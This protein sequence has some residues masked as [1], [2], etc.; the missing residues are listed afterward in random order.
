MADPAGNHDQSPDRGRQGGAERRPPGDP[1]PR[2]LTAR[3]DAA[4]PQRPQPARDDTGATDE[5]DGPR[6][7]NVDTALEDT[8][9]IGLLLRRVAALAWKHKVAAPPV[10]AVT[11]AAQGLILVCYAAQGLAVD[12]LHR[13]ADPGARKIDLP[14]G[15]GIPADW[16]LATSVSVISGVVLLAA[17]LAAAMRYLQRV[18]EEAFAQRCIIDV[19]RRMYDKLQRL[20]FGFFDEHETGQ[21]IQRL[22]ADAQQVRM[23]VQGL[24][25][26]MVI[27]IVTLAIFLTYMLDQSVWLTLTVLAVL[28]V[29][30][31]AV[32]RYGRVT[33]PRFKEQARL[34]DT[35]VH[36]LS[37]AIAGVRVIRAFGRQGHVTERF[38]RDADLAKK[39]RIDLARSQGRYIPAVQAGNLLGT[40]VLVCVGVL[41]VLDANAE[42]DAAAAGAAAATGLTLGALWSFRGLLRSLS[43]QLESIMWFAAQAPESLA[44]AD[45]VFRMLEQ[46]EKVTDNI[47]IHAAQHPRADDADDA[48][49]PR[50]AQPAF[51]EGGTW[52]GPL[53][54]DDVS[55]RYKPHTPDVLSNVEL[56]IEPG[57]TVAVVGRTGSGKSTLLSLVSR[58][59]DPTQGRITLGG[60]DLKDLPLR[61]LRRRV[62]WVFQEPFL[63]SNTVHNN[64]A[65]GAPAASREEVAAAADAAQAADFIAELNASY[66][67][68]VGE[69]GVD[70]SGGQRQRLTIARALV[71]DPDILVLDDALTAVDPVTE[72]LIQQAL[73]HSGPKRTTIIVAHRL[74]TLRRADRIV[75]IER[76]A[77]AGVG[78][79]EQLVNQPGHYREA[80][81]IQLALDEDDPAAAEPRH[82]MRDQPAPD[83]DADA[84]TDRETG[85]AS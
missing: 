38:D 23:L 10:L 53:V 49:D 55:F 21:I 58:L 32:A 66:E 60:V 41:L 29:Q 48:D 9:P 64:I 12:V 80:A 74:S 1:E 76:G 13:A 36:R 81:L 50:H 24:L 79:H 83:Y 30:S 78:T 57:E 27:A 3:P 15:L 22:T 63:F 59:H 17:V 5:S 40:G 70:L 44:G 26:R 75:V 18:T 43:G 77:I 62:A 28:P 20:D 65:F 37:E 45:R 39:H 6:Q 33:K 47:A 11:V 71:T 61:E 67:T 42:A 2:D 4:D 68:V 69:R 16:S 7:R 19:R 85:A 52:R 14:L 56:R 73:E 72:A 82:T 46:D 8:L 54:F 84:N 25:V 31:W 35:V 34:V 51:T